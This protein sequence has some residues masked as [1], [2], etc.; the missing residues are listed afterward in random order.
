M[1][2]QKNPNLLKYPYLYITKLFPLFS[3]AEGRNTDT[4]H[5]RTIAQFLPKMSVAT[6]T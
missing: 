2:F 5:K 1:A 6:L 3:S 4:N